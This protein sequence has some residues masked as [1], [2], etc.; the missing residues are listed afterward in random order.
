MENGCL[1]SRSCGRDNSECRVQFS[2][3]RKFH[4]KWKFPEIVEK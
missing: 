1:G 3:F 4:Q 2:N